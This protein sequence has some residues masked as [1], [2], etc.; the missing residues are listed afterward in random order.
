MVLFMSPVSVSLSPTQM[1]V[2]FFGVMV[3]KGKHARISMSSKQKS[4][5]PSMVG[6]ALLMILYWMDSHP[7]GS[8]KE[9]PYSSHCPC[10]A[11]SIS[12]S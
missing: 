6:S 4:L 1:E 10:L 8:M 3:G 12:M 7:E 9:N 11:F 2:P 5:P